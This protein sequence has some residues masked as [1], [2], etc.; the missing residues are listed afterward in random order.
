MR[1]RTPDRLAVK[2]TLLVVSILVI[3]GGAI[4]APTLPAIRAQ[5][6]DTENI[7]FW[8]R[9]VLTLPP[10]LIALSAPLAGYLVDTTGRKIVLVTATVMAGLAGVSGYFLQTFVTV[11]IGRAILGLAVAGLMTS[12]T[13]LIADYYY[14]AERSRVMG[15]QAGFMGLAGTLLLLLTGT[16]ADIGWRAPFLVHLMAFA[17]LPFVLIFI[18]EPR[19]PERCLEKPPAQ[20]EACTCV[21]QSIQEAKSA[22]PIEEQPPTPVRLI[23][24]IYGVILVVEIVFYVVPI[25]LPFYLQD[26]V[27]SSATQTG[28]AISAMSL[29]FAVSSFFYGRVARRLDHIAVLMIGFVLMG[30]G[31][32]LVTFSQGSGLLYVG[33]VV[34]GLGIGQLIPNLYVWLA[35]ETPAQVRGR[36][37]GGFTTALFLGQFLSPIVSQPIASSFAPANT[38]LIAGLVLLALVPS[39]FVGR[40]RLRLIAAQPA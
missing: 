30:V 14:G 20:A 28:V 19:L 33:L 26:V 15:L 29:S 16:L 3:F 34:S 39:L 4:M 7:D 23:A 6:A 1:E 31:Y 32:A 38:F 18:Y 35:D 17:I 12:T 8:V 40:G 22:G 37:I 36:V 11:L 24:F 2:G 27:G 21:A 9:F 25:H 10:L 13:T 5:F